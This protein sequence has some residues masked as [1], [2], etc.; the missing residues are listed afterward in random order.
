M[1]KPA[2]STCGQD[3]VVGGDLDAVELRPGV[4]LRAGPQGGAGEGAGDDL[5]SGA[6][7]PRPWPRGSG[8]EG[9]SRA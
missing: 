7:L 5:R 9:G 3:V 4:H 8:V 1:E 6:V 2:E